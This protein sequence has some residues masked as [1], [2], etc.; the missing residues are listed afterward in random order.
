MSIDTKE[1]YDVTKVLDEYR[2]ISVFGRTMADG[3]IEFNSTVQSPCRK[4]VFKADSI[5]EMRVKIDIAL[6]S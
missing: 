5:R 4:Y 6:D 1:S 2:G 3:E